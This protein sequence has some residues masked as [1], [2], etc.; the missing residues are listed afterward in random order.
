MKRLFHST[1]V[2]IGALVDEFLQENTLILFDHDVPAELH[3]MAVLHT[4]SEQKEP[5]KPGDYLV[6][7]EHRLRVTCVGEKANE[8]LLSIGHCTLKADGS[9]A[10]QLPGTIHLEAAQI[11]PL[12]IGSVLAFV[13]I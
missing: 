2:Q 12:E 11:P 5:V 3:D 10:P 13:R 9:E 1:I 4:K 7:G 6:I 8:T